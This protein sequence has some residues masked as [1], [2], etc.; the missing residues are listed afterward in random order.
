MSQ[1]EQMIQKH[2]LNFL[3]SNKKYSQVKIPISKRRIGIDYR[4]HFEDEWDSIGFLFYK[5]MLSRDGRLYMFKGKPYTEKKFKRIKGFHLGRRLKRCVAY[6]LDKPDWKMRHKAE[7]NLS[8]YAFW[9]I[10]KASLILSIV[11][12]PCGFLF[13]S[14][15]P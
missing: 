15:R 11:L 7:K 12:L 13:L 10:F 2:F 8:R 14:S 3:S 1:H 5:S 9:L 4:V 6:W